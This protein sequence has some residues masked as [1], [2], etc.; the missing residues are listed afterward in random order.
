MQAAVVLLVVSY[1]IWFPTS[2]WRSG[3]EYGVDKGYEGS[4]RATGIA[5]ERAYYYP[6]TGLLPV[7]LGMEEIERKNLPIPP[8][9]GAIQGQA[10]S[11]ADV[12]HAIAG[13]VGFFGY[14]AG[15]DKYLVDSWALSDP[16]LARIPYEKTPDWR[17]GHFARSLPEGYMQSRVSGENLL[18]DPKLAQLYDSVN[19]V[20]QGELFGR[21]RWSEIWG[22]NFG[23][24][25]VSEE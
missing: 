6:R 20:T 11:R 2:R 3:S 15:P 16:F 21:E 25:D 10:F 23:Y 14:N 22:Y 8:Y 24:R 7:L 5:D 12:S 1:G 17:I 18:D 19:R 4:V 9:M 13:E